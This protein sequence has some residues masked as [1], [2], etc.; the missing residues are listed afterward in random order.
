VIGGFR[1]GGAKWTGIH[2][3]LRRAP[4]EV[5]AAGRR[6]ADVTTDPMFVRPVR[7]IAKLYDLQVSP[8]HRETMTVRD[9]GGEYGASFLIPRTPADLVKRRESMKLWPKPHSAWSAARR[10]ISTPC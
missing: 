9:D 8:A 6:I 7:S 2:R 10:I 3:G 1:N 4:R 5:W